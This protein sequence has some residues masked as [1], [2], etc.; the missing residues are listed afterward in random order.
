MAVHRQIAAVHRV[1]V[2]E[3]DRERGAE[4]RVHRLAQHLPRMQHAH[5]L[6]RQLHLALRPL[7]DEDARL[8]GDQLVAE[9]GV[10]GLRSETQLALRP[11]TAPRRGVEVRPGAHRAAGQPRERGPHPVPVQPRRRRGLLHVQPAVDPG[12][13]GVPVPVE[14]RPVHVEQPPQ[15]GRPAGQAQVLPAARRHRGLRV[16]LRQVRVPQH[17]VR[18]Q[19]RPG[20]VHQQQPVG[21]ARHGRRSVE[22]V[23]QGVVRQAREIGV[24]GLLGQGAAAHRS[25]RRVVRAHV[26]RAHRG[27]AA[28]QLL[29]QPG[30]Q[31]GPVHGRRSFDRDDRRASG[32]SRRHGGPPGGQGRLRRRGVARIEPVHA[33]SLRS[34][35]S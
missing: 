18:G 12:R 10:P 31:R 27:P 6:E 9:G 15:L 1:Q 22:Q 32:K 20:A 2:V 30:G 17:V 5:Q 21:G 11:V 16:P 28:G 13:Q 7:A 25:R 34:L 24:V 33:F 29:P 14:H 35:L 8:R 19:R 23:V 26:Q 4:R 3:A